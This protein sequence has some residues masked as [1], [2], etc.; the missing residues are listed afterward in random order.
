VSREVSRC[1]GRCPRRCWRCSEVSSEVL[2]GAGPW[3]RR[4]R[5][6][7]S[8]QPSRMSPKNHHCDTG[9][10]AI[11][12]GWQFGPRSFLGIETNVFNG[13]HSG[14]D[15]VYLT[16]HCSGKSAPL[17]ASDDTMRRNPSRPS[18]SVRSRGRRS[19]YLIS[20]LH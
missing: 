7:G 9:K 15:C 12:F 11:L 17:K 3:G 20:G 18:Y 2:R 8:S 14:L 13:E 5:R 1:R 16:I 4:G 6:G 19:P 10:S